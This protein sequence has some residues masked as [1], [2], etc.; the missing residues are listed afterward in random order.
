MGKLIFLVFLFCFSFLHSNSDNNSRID[1]FVD[2]ILSDSFYQKSGENSENRNTKIID[3][4]KVRTI[5][6]FAEL[7]DEIVRYKELGWQSSTIPILICRFQYFEDLLTTYSSIIE[8]LDL[9]LLIQNLELVYRRA[10]ARKDVVIRGNYS[11]KGAPSPRIIEQLL[12]IRKDYEFVLNHAPPS[13]RLYLATQIKMDHLDNILLSP[14]ND[15][16]IHNLVHD[17][18]PIELHLNEWATEPGLTGIEL[19]ENVFLNLQKCSEAHDSFLDYVLLCQC[20]PDIALGYLKPDAFEII[21]EAVPDAADD[22]LPDGYGDRTPALYYKIQIGT[23]SGS[24]WKK[25][26]EL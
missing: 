25:V 8:K 18:V 9:E 19:R 5:Q 14:L 10:I 16:D 7:G 21:W 26:C 11:L 20:D 3:I 23:D 15:F 2:W 22:Y 12:L 4:E 13:S 17:D 24:N 1:Q 6:G